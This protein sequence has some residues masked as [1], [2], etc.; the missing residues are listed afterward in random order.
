MTITLEKATAEDAEALHAMQIKCFLPLLEKYKDHGTNPACEPI[1][2]TLTRITDPLKGFYKILK[3]NI[4]VG[5]IVVKHTNPGTLFLGPIF[6]APEF[7][8]QKIA[9]KALKLIEDVFP[10]IDF[11]ELATIAEEKRNV[12]LYE[13]MGYIVGCDKN[14]D[15]CPKFTLNS[16]LTF[17]LTSQLKFFS[18]NQ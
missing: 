11:F 13:K 12:Y 7:Q 8:N 9:Q 15:E 5:G 1:D 16:P 4:L 14:F 6:I 17:S 2:K 18:S 10:A 3:N